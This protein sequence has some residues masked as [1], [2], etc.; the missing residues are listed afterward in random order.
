MTKDIINK[1]ITWAILALI[2]LAITLIVFIAKGNTW[3][4]QILAACLG[5]IITVIVTRLLLSKQSEIDERLNNDKNNHET[6]LVRLKA[7]Y[8]TALKDAEKKSA[9]ELEEFRHRSAQQ[10]KE[11]EEKSKRSLE[12][13]N[14]KLKV[15]SNFVSRMYGILSDNK[16]EESEMLELRTR[17]FGQISFYANADILE[18]INKELANIEDYTVTQKMQR[19]FANIACILQQDLRNDWP[20][21]MHSAYTLWDTFDKLLDSKE[22]LGSNLSVATNLQSEIPE[23]SICLNNTF[24]HFAMWGSEQLKALSEGIYE[25]NLVEYGEEWRTNLIGQ[26]KKDDLVFLFRSG[27]PGYMGVYRARGWRLFEFGANGACTETVNIFGEYE[28]HYTNDNDEG[29]AQIE[30]DLERSD[31]YVSRADGATL[32]SSLIVEPLAF[33]N[34]GIGN[35]GGT[36]RRTISRYDH[37]Y[38][39]MQLARFMAIKDD[40]NVYNVYENKEMG[41]NKELFEKILASGN[42]QKAKRD[43]NGNWA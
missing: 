31:I 37:G 33:A 36:Y 15:Y 11:T 23:S 38:G 16:I 28:R 10:L 14:A 8:D 39:L 2:L 9:R 35:P 18:K 32:C 40:I 19:K 17:I 21:N 25:L 34:A 20:A 7:E 43:E 4:T 41:C 12:I 30:K 5:A 6:E 22:G 1:D 27:G 29:K 13:Y 24:W 26:V 3:A 42:I